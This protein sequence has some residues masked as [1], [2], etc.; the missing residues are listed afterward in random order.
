MRKLVALSIL[1]IVA[2]LVATFI[3]AGAANAA[4]SAAMSSPGTLARLVDTRAGAGDVPVRSDLAMDRG[5]AVSV[6]D[7]LE[8]EMVMN[9]LSQLA[10]MPNSVVGASNASTTAMARGLKA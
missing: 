9:H 5:S 10:E 8:M 4:P 3:M 7:M 6:W 2:V 1:S